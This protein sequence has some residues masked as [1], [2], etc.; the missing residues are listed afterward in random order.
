MEDWR[1]IKDADGSVRYYFNTQTG[2]TSQERP[3]EL[4]GVPSQQQQPV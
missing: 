2:V 1:E 4:G 3:K